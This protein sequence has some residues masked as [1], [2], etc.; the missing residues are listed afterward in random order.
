MDS[1]ST[2]NLSGLETRALRLNSLGGL[3]MAVLGLGFAVLTQ[4]EAILL[5]GFFSLIG[6]AV[7]LLTQKVARLALR[8][9]DQHYPF[10]YV[11]FEPMLNLSK[12]LLTGL[13]GLFA[14]ISAVS[15]LLTG[16]RPTAAGI[17]VIYAVIASLGCFGFA[18]RID[19]LAKRS[20][21]S[22]VAVDA[23]N[24]MLGGCISVAVAITF[25]LVSWTK[26]TTLETWA[27]YAD[28]LIVIVIVVF[29]IPYPAKIIRKAWRQ[30]IGYR[31]ESGKMAA[32]HTAIEEMFTPAGTVTWQVRALEIGRLVF[33]QVYVLDPYQWSGNLV[34]QDQLRSQ[35]YSKL[36][37]HFTY[38]Q[39]D[40]IFTQQN[41]W[42]NG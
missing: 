34:Q 42:L 16:G 1:I 31:P 17:A 29:M 19:L 37:Q 15:A 2:N 36:T 40:V 5:D 8:P 20:K 9:G 39:L 6:F 41:Q 33:V 23:K 26:G 35:L 18:W 25:L 13:I 30:I 28:S 10:G 12:G 14:L 7:S 21:S 11:T 22:F 27:P 3:A 38:C 24:W 4:S 32:I